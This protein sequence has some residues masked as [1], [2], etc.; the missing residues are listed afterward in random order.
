MRTDTRDYRPTWKPDW[1]DAAAHHRQ[2]WRGEGLVLSV[3]APLPEPRIAVD[4]PPTPDSLRARWLDP[5]YRARR[6]EAHAARTH[7]GGDAVPIGGCLVGAGDLGALLGCAYGFAETTCWFEPCIDDPDTAA[8]IALDPANANFIAL[9]EMLT[10]A[11]RIADGRY[12]IG[13]PDLVENVDILAAMRDPQTLM[14]DLYDRPEW[15]LEKLGE[16]NA[17]YFEA[18]DRF[19]ALLGLPDGSSCFDAF[20]VWGPGRVAKVQCDAAAMLS[21]Q[22]FRKFVTPALTAQ[23]DWLDHAMYH[24]DGEDALPCLDELLAIEPL[25]AIEWTPRMAYTGEGGGH[26][27]WYELYRRILAAGKSVQAISVKSDEV[28]PLLDAVGGAGMYIVTR[29]ESPESAEALVERASAYR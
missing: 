3:N 4:P 7:F 22:M 19:N 14:V 11:Q 24:L 25:D 29:A 20:S 1:P 26:P 10:E 9:Y 18:Y 16:I 12:M 6:A 21:P 13:L 17:A 15:V 27:R 8:P 28:I 23:C 2:W 5:T